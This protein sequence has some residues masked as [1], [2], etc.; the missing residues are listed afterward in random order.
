ME[1]KKDV[2][3][4]INAT[5]RTIDRNTG[6]ILETEKLHNIIVDN[7]LERIA[8]RLFS[9]STDFYDYI[10]IGIGTTLETAIDTT[11]ETEVARQ[12]AGLTYVA[13]NKAEFTK[14]FTFG[15]AEVYNITEAGIFDDAISSGSTMLNR[16]VFASKS[17]DVDTSLSVTISI[18]VG[19]L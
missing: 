5:I 16:L 14:V 7:G 9:N 2:S 8:R 17:V 12:L 11:L 15:S 3:V 10:A 19:R 1:N 6:K 4:K 18:S 13:A